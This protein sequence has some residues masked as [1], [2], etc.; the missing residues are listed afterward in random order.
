[1]KGLLYERRSQNVLLTQSQ[2]MERNTLIRLM[3]KLREN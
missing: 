2:D 3:N 1:M